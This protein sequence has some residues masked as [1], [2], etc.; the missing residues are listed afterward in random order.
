MKNPRGEEESRKELSMNRSPDATLKYI[1]YLAPDRVE[2]AR[3]LLASLP[4]GWERS[5]PR[6]CKHADGSL[7]RLALAHAVLEILLPGTTLP[8]H[9][10]RA[11]AVYIHELY[12]LQQKGDSHE[13]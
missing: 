10:V 3:R 12:R 11:L 7:S 1:R 6:Q 8:S 5:V 2:E 13:R 9:A 4:A